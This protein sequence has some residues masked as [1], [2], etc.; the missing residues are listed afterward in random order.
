MSQTPSR[1]K[2][3]GHQL[4][5]GP[6]LETPRKSFE[7]DVAPQFIDPQKWEIQVAICS[8]IQESSEIRCPACNKALVKPNTV[9][10]GSSLPGALLGNPRT[11]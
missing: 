6:A 5:L 2:L 11:C 9:L 8:E 1:N 4:W 3:F 10:F 7:I